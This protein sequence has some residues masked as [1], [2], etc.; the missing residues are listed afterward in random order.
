MLKSEK[1]V[2]WKIV[3][4]KYFHQPVN[5]RQFWT[6]YSLPNMWQSNCCLGKEGGRV[7]V[8]LVGGA[9]GP[10]VQPSRC[11]SSLAWRTSLF[12]PRAGLLTPARRTFRPKV[13]GDNEGEGRA[14]REVAAGC[15]WL[16]SV[17]SIHPS[18]LAG[19]FS[20]ICL[21]GCP[22]SGAQHDERSWLRCRLC[23]SCLHLGQR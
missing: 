20:L 13:E 19:S 5:L 6:C 23:L 22:L 2:F 17:A 11:S 15:R 14:A 21:D 9:G 18:P 7:L 4:Q 1:I 10:S 8:V 12:P 3:R 16:G